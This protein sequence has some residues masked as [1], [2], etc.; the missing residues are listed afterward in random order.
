MK[1]LILILIII[2]TL[3]TISQ[4]IGL[5]NNQVPI[6]VMI[7]N[8]K[9]ARPQYGIGSA[10][11]VYEALAEGGIT[12]FMA[13]F[14]G[15]N[16]AKI[17]PIRSA[18]EY[19]VKLAYPY[20]GLYV[21]CGGS[22]Y[23]YISIKKLGLYDLDQLVHEGYFKRDHTKKAP[24]NLFT[25]TMLLKKAIAK[26]HLLPPPRFPYF[27]ANKSF[28]KNK[29]PI[30]KIYIK[31]NKMYALSYVYNKEK[32]N[33]TRYIKNIP[34]KDALTNKPIEVK[35]II[36]LY[37]PTYIRKND[38]EGRL[39]MKIEGTG[40]GILFT[41]GGVLSIKWVK[42]PKDPIY[43]MNKSGGKITLNPGITW[44]QIIPTDKGKVAYK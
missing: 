38:K 4:G 23:A 6:I 22:P 34:W 44:V 36:I 19:F 28:L 24:H 29:N 33:Y 37:V 15:K 8:H 3:G 20:K 41:G 14:I 5:A 16:I 17:G 25:S 18:R 13:I 32:N 26:F 11:I 35:N 31:Y 9:D 7:D 10:D 42:H 43:L 21:H 30:K 1:K 2:S 27:G 12:R 40:K 39:K